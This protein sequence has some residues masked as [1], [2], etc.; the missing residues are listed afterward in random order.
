MNGAIQL[1]K[2]SRAACA[3]RPPCRDTLPAT[4]AFR[5]AG[6]PPAGLTFFF[7][8][9]FAFRARS[10]SQ[11]RWR[12]ASATGTNPPGKRL[13][14]ETASRIEIR[15]TRSFKRRKHFLIET[16][17]ANCVASGT[18][19]RLAET[20]KINRDISLIESP[21]NHWKQRTAA[22]INRN[23]SHGTGTPITTRWQGASERLSWPR[24]AG[25]NC[26]GAR[27]FNAD[28]EGE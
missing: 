16:R 21:V 13:L 12:D 14:I 25:A 26:A 18:R 28:D 15:V 19:L 22:S 5:S 2:D 27:R 1:G 24:R 6:V 7:A 23:I 11:I 3:S 8:V 9:A 17:T 4:A 20:A 10:Q